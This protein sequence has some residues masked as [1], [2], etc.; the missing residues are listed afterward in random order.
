[1]LRR[2]P[3]QRFY[4]SDERVDIHW[5]GEHAAALMENRVRQLVYRAPLLAKKYDIDT[6]AA[7]DIT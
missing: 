6:A 4:L 2:W 3:D 7:W 1:M 5:A